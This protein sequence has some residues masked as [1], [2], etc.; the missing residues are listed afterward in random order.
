MSR[1][2]A[3]FA[4]PV[5][6]LVL[7]LVASSCGRST[8]LGPEEAVEVMV[9]DGVA[10]ARAVCIVENVGGDLDLA[11]VSGLEIDLTA[12]ELRLL[13]ATS[14][15]CAPAM[16][17]NG[18]VVIGRPPLDEAAVAAEMA[19]GDDLVQRSVARLVDEGLEFAV[20]QCLET[21]LDGR[22]D[23]AEALEDV[24]QRSALIVDCRVQLGIGDAG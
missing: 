16:A 2:P 6:L 19:A 11:K 4:L 5:C 24:V 9:L 18:P 1:F 17:L 8:T 21:M 3:S 20:G 7:G 14:A 10:R 22:D 12:D 13:A 23:A 15:Q